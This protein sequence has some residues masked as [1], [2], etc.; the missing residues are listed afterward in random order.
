MKKREDHDRRKTIVVVAIMIPITLLYF[1][2]GSH[3]SGPFPLFVNGYLIDILLPFG[4][5]FLL[6][7]NDN[8][9]LSSW[10][11]RG[12]LIFTAASAVEL[13]QYNDIPL[14]GRTFDPIDII[15]YG[16]GVILAILF[17]L[18]IF[19]RLFSFWKPRLQS[20]R[21]KAEEENGMFIW[22]QN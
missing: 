22:R 5:Y 20:P 13:A 15:M 17:D 4:F 6:C 11:A 18:F 8:A 2:T 3:Y 9:I 10:I 12:L 19:P 14:L 1:V 21:S 16:F 7:L